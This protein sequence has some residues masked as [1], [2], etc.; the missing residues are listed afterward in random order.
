[1]FQEDELRIQRIGYFEDAT[2]IEKV[3]SRCRMC[4]L[5][6]S[7]SHYQVSNPSRSR[8]RVVTLGRGVDIPITCLNCFDAPCID[9]CPTGAMH[10]LE[11]GDMVIVN[12]D[13]CIGCGMCVN[14]CPIGAITLDPV[15]NTAAKCDLCGG[16]PQCIKYC[17]PRV[18]QLTDG[19]TY[20]RHRMRVFAKSLSRKHE[21]E[22]NK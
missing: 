11:P 5:I 16:D 20:A 4:E 12:S 17:P 22:E 19:L 21:S 15:E 9:I 8:I 18:L 6:C 7:F 14:A 2:D 13:T 1:M 10:R 3:C